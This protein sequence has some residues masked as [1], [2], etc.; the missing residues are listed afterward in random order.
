MQSQLRLRLPCM[1]QSLPRLKPRSLHP[2]PLEQSHFQ[3]SGVD[4]EC[5][6]TEWRNGE[7]FDQQCNLGG[8]IV[9]HY[10]VLFGWW[11][12]RPIVRDN[13]FC[14][15]PAVLTVTANNASRPYDTANP[16]FTA[17]YS[18][19]VN[20]DTSAV[21]SG[22]PSL[23]TTATITSPAGNYPITAATGTLSAANYTFSF[24]N[25][26]L[27]VTQIALVPGISFTLTSSPNPSNYGQSV[28]FTAT[29]PPAATGTMQFLDNGVA[30]GS[31]V[32]VVGGVA[33]YTT[34]ALAV[35][36]RPSPRSIPATATTA[37]R[38][39]QRSTRL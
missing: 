8:W 14:V 34:S 12:P 20:G 38:P 36:I 13:Q 23:T 22:A 33:I 6:R 21:L 4:I 15:T 31:P 35:R 5:N 2:A 24:G 16:A 11:L 30:M 9:H 19:F 29:I 28:T 39:R 32:A 18:G 10:R 37:L 25:G 27:A 17:G 1:E 7:H 3:R 26:S